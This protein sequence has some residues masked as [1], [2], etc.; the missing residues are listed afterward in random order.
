M[1]KSGLVTA[2][3]GAITG[4]VLLG[5]GIYY[6]VIKQDNLG[7]RFER[8]P[9][10]ME[11]FDENYNVPLMD[12]FGEEI[13][14]KLTLTAELDEEK[15]ILYF[16]N[17]TQDYDK[18]DWS[19][20]EKELIPINE[21]HTNI[22]YVY[23]KTFILHPPEVKIS[24]QE[25]RAFLVPQYAWDLNLK[26]YEEHQEAQM[27]IEGG[28]KIIDWA[29]GKIPIPFFK[30]FIEEGFE[31]ATEKEEEYYEEMFNRLKEGYTITIIPS[32]IPNKILGYTETAREYKIYFDMSEVEGEVPIYLWTKIALGDPS[33]STDNEFPNKYGELENIVIGFSLKRGEGIREEGEEEREIKNLGLEDYFL[34]GKE[35]EG[36][37]LAPDFEGEENP[38]ILTPKKMGEARANAPYLK[39]MKNLG[40]ALYLIPSKEEEPSE[41]TFMVTQ[42][43]TKINGWEFLSKMQGEGS[44]DEINIALIKDDTFCFIS[45]EPETLEQ[46]S[47]FVDCLINYQNRIKWDEISSKNLDEIYRE[48]NSPNLENI[49]SFFNALEFQKE[50]YSMGDFELKEYFE[51]IT[52]EIENNPN[53]QKEMFKKIYSIFMFPQL[54]E[55]I[56]NLGE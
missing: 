8:P 1:K 49:T 27:M 23:S 3:T 24:Q 42:F 26:P 36:I 2:I 15:N 46:E 34:Q 17:Y 16:G 37:E 7:G 20:T 51:E 19:G 41:I 5:A 11:I 18:E 31:N 45:Y 22:N 30:E 43:D 52:K 33:I 55:R 48:L 4:V 21:R 25:Q 38:W 39:T 35:L 44:W 29:L 13:S 14:E 54:E 50:I 28:E 12:E 40:G 6:S 10:A 32:Q 53:P 47:A 9:Q 56:K